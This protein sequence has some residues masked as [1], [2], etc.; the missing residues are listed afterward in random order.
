MISEEASDQDDF[1]GNKEN[2]NRD[3]WE[4][5]A[6]GFGSILAQLENLSFALKKSF[7][8]AI[9]IVNREYI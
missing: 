3:M 4:K 1:G 7:I 9:W 6:P 2:D 8:F 5:A